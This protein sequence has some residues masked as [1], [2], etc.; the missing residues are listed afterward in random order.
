MDLKI[1]IY[2][3]GYIKACVHGLSL[4]GAMTVIK[5]HYTEFSKN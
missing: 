1:N 3:F 4:R 5:T 2:G